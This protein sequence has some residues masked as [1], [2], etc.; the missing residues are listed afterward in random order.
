MTF[1]EAF[2]AFT[3]LFFTIDALGILPMFISQTSTLSEPRRK[4][5][6]KEASLTALIAGILFLFGGP[7]LFSVLGITADDFRIGGGILLFLIA[8]TDILFSSQEKR[9]GPDSEEV[10]VVPIGIPLMLGPGAMTTLIMLSDKFGYWITL[11]SLVINLLIA[12][13]VFY[14]ADWLVKIMGK[15]VSTAFGKI[16][17][18]FLIAIA[19][20]M[21]R[22][23]VCNTFPNLLCTQ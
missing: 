3:P 4:K 6:T 2:L 17:S 13:V 11:G 9:R 16:A 10:G 1:N 7:F 20:M 22:V 12:F 14:N 8:I 15:G 23:G 21:I 19:I 5:L 18:L